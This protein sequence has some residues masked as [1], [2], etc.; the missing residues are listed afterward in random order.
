[1]TGLLD[2]PS[3]DDQEELRRRSHVAN[4]D[5]WDVSLLSSSKVSTRGPEKDARK[6]GR[7]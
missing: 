3:S 1:M 2:R 4:D 7:G 5:T 6:R